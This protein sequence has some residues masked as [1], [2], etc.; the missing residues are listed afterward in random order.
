MVLD[1]FDLNW[2][3]IDYKIYKLIVKRISCKILYKSIL[4]ID[5]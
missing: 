4:K 3:F 1:N 2:I 5:N